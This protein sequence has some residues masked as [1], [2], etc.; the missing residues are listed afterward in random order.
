MSEE[1][2][3]Q[4]MITLSK[5][6]LNKSWWNWVCWGQICYN[7]ERMMGLGFCHS[8]IPILKGLYGNDKEKLAEG[9]TRHLTFYN[10][11]NTWGAVIPGIVASLEEGRANGQDIDDET[12]DNLKTGLMGPL[13]G[14][15]DSITQSLVKVILLS[16]AIDMALS[17]SAIG[18]LIFIVGFSVYALGVSRFVYFQGYKFGKTAIM[19]LLGN[20]M[21]KDI[22]EALGALGMMILGG[23]IANNIPVKTPLTY[24]LQGMT[25]EIQSMLNSIMPN[26]LPVATF[27][28]VVIMLRKGLKPTRIM[29]ILMIASVVFGLL[30]ILA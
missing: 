9:M 11:E 12:I 28:A 8:M 23:L 30:G 19:K 18:T 25:S 24:S 13:A 10:T 27:V 4:D 26:L 17:G 29:V 20:G 7:Y 21:I 3:T 6:D 16:I 2:K 22:T 5:K 15:G 14:L 1:M